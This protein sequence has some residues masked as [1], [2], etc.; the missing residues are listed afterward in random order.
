MGE[1][2]EWE[3]EWKYP[4]AEAALAKLQQ[5]PPPTGWTVRT[6]PSGEVYYVNHATRVT[7]WN[8]WTRP[9]QNRRSVASS[10]PVDEGAP[11][12]AFVFAPIFLILMLVFFMHR[13]RIQAFF[14]ESEK[15][16]LR[17]GLRGIRK[18]PA[19]MYRRH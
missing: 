18:K 13:R 16:S 1:F 17:G 4:E 6:E 8:P 19:M 15:P 7:T 10:L 12:S 11:N 3:I 5:G 9:Q 2:T 14:S